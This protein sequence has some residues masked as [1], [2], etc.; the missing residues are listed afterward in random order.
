MVDEEITR[1][2]RLDFE[3]AAKVHAAKLEGELVATRRAVE[4]VYRFLSLAAPGKPVLIV[5]DDDP[6]VCSA[7]RR[8]SRDIGEMECVTAEQFEDAMALLDQAKRIDVVIL[9]HMLDNGHI[10]LEYLEAMRQLWPDVPVIVA[11][12]YD[13]DKIRV[14]YSA[15]GMREIYFEP[16]PMAVR[17]VE[18]IVERRKSDPPRK[19]PPGGTPK[20]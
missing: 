10:G 7:W 19:S 15:V 12:G 16:K 2:F 18:K 20:P 17:T 9:D 13:D 8:Y 5:V 11:S 14:M 6:S 1:R 3:D 4:L